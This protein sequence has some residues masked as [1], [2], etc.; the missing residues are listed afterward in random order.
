VITE[1]RSYSPDQGWSGAG[2]PTLDSEQ[3]LV[4]AFGAPECL[5]RSTPLRELAAAYPRA[6]LLGCSTAGEILGTSIRDGGVAAAICRFDDTRLRAASAPVTSPHDSEAAGR[7][8]AAALLAPDLRG[9]IVVSDGLRVNGTELLRGLNG[10]LPPAVVVTGGLAG[11]GP[12]FQRT[13]VLHQ[14]HPEEGRVSAVGL[15]GDRLSIAHGSQGGWDIFGPERTVTRS[16][17][18]VLHEIDGRPAL[19]LYKAYLGELAAG[20]PANALLFPLSLRREKHDETRVVRTILAVNE[21]NQSLT[22]AGDIPCG[23][24][25]QLMRANFDRLID[26]A[27]EAATLARHREPGSGRGLAI[28]VSCVGRRLVLGERA[29]EEVEAVLDTLPP[30]SALVGFYSYGEISPSATGRCELHNQ[31]MTL[32]HYLER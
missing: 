28:A 19:Q 20:L 14:G 15:Y 7:T 8:I 17:G 12:R 31:T 29:E 26:G 4:I 1:L 3:T 32:T 10:V 18:N 24:L 22:F 23:S 5:E 9:V 11:D 25:V 27:I 30:G 13:W 21:A 16:E 6:R 2:L